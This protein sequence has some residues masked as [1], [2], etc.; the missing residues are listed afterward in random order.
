MF[1]LC[2]S[3]EMSDL[4]SFK[5]V[6]WNWQKGVRYRMN[7]DIDLF[8]QHG[9]VGL[10]ILIWAS[11]VVVF[12]VIATKLNSFLEVNGCSVQQRLKRITRSSTCVAKNK[13]RL[14]SCSFIIV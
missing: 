10:P 3:W 9:G 1:E 14:V 6:P 4:I 11:T 2:M 5:F 7:Y 13:L 12:S 8:V